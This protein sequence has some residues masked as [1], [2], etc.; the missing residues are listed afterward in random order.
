L[1]SLDDIANL[2]FAEGHMA[3]TA[4]SGDA[5]IY[6]PTTYSSFEGDAEPVISLRMKI[7]AGTLSQLYF[8]A[9]GAPFG[10]VTRV[11]SSASTTASGIA[12][13]WT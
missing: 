8:N 2:S 5:R 13:K 6:G 12:T 11:D 10:Q 1:G 9:V 3:G 7:S 4:T